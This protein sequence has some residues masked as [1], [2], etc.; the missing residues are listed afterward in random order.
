[1]IR[2]KKLLCVMAVLCML[3]CVACGAEDPKNNEDK[4]ETS[5]TPTTVASV[6]PRTAI[7]IG[8]EVCEDWLEPYVKGFNESQTEYE[9]KIEGYAMYDSK[10][11]E[12]H[13]DGLFLEEAR[14]HKT[15]MSC[16]LAKQYE[17]IKAYI[18]SDEH[19]YF[20]SLFVEEDAGDKTLWQSDKYTIVLMEH[21]A[22]KAGVLAFLEYMENASK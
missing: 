19:E 11:V 1:M 9:L 4:R 15:D 7:T 3:A 10:D 17:D 14:A 12:Y 16:F 18:A 8:T 21:S 13:C 5:I 22:Q 6:T 2:A 20:V